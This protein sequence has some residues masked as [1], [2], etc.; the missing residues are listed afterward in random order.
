M[1]RFL[2]LLSLFI[3]FESNA[4]F[5]ETYFENC[6]NESDEF[7]SQFVATHDGQNIIGVYPAEMEGHTLQWVV[8]PQNGGATF[9]QSDVI[10][11]EIGVTDKLLDLFIIGNQQIIL[12]QNTTGANPKGI[13]LI[14]Y[15][16]YENYSTSLGIPFDWLESTVQ[17]QRIDNQLFLFP[18]DAAGN[19]HKI[20][21]DLLN[22]TLVSDIVLIPGFPFEDIGSSTVLHPTYAI[23]KSDLQ[24]EQIVVIENDILYRYKYFNN[25][26]SSW[27]TS[28]E[29]FKGFAIDLKNERILLD[30]ASDGGII[31]QLEYSND[32]NINV[33]TGIPL[34][35]NDLII[36]SLITVNNDSIVVT[37]LE[38]S[39]THA[40][41]YNQFGIEIKQ[42]QYN[43]L[44]LRSLT[45]VN[46]DLFCFGTRY[47][48]YYDEFGTNEKLAPFISFCSFDNLF[49]FKEYSQLLEFGEMKGL[50]L[51]TAPIIFPIKNNYLSGYQS[52]TLNNPFN[53]NTYF[54]QLDLAGNDGTLYRGGVRNFYSSFKPGPYTYSF[55]YSYQDMYR[56]NKGIFIDRSMIVNHINAVQ[57]GSSS[58]IPIDAILNWPA[59]GDGFR[60]QATQLAPFVDLN[61]NQLYE[62]LLGDYPSF[63]GF[64]CYYSIA[65]QHENDN[66]YTGSG[67]ELHQFIYTQSCNDTIARTLFVKTIVINRS[68]I[69]YDSLAIGIFS[70]FDMAFFDNDYPSF[71]VTTGLGYIYNKDASDVINS[72]LHD[73]IPA[74]GVTILKGVKIENDGLD[75]TIGISGNTTV[76]GFGMNDGIIDNE[77]FGTNFGIDYN[78]FATAE[79]S[80]PS[81]THQFFN[82]LNGKTRYGNP[83][84]YQ[85]ILNSSSAEPAT[86]FRFTGDSDPLH[87]STY[88]FDPGFELSPE[89]CT[90]TGS[91]FR[92][93]NSTGST[94][95][96][97][98]DSITLDFA[99]SYGDGFPSPLQSVDDL[100]TRIATSKAYFNANETPCGQNFDFIDEED[101]L[102]NVNENTENQIV[103]YPNPTKNSFSILSDIEIKNCTILAIDGTCIGQYSQPIISV[104]DFQQGIYIII[105]ED[106][107][108]NKT[109]TR[110]I[111]N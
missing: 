12:S 51:G 107:V 77:Y 56:Y 50:F 43:M 70:D 54:S 39:I 101:E 69:N 20:T 9:Y 104:T 35:Y 27:E 10:F 66:S 88:G 31:I 73:S 89:Y 108:G 96:Y 14:R 3:I 7:A 85:C 24:Y 11:E 53:K 47:G 45:V 52:T 59:H 102:L 100:R 48:E 37:Y 29:P 79:F 60:G 36:P 28:T 22:L 18:I 44:K 4:Q 65:H 17:H 62:P 95:L 40:I 34:M 78:A 42:K 8:K 75:N 1:K 16:D 25:S 97:T 64:T 33:Q 13:R 109:T 63:P 2:Y 103:L 90:S 61:N 84:Q 68:T 21:V 58:Y 80:D 6:E 30:K 15:T 106:V 93:L 98:N 71:D 92:I 32:L 49:D 55:D 19:L 111:K 41:L 46:G 83:I 110:L 91:D 86:R 76:N 94:H 87:F 5:N 72:V 38:N 81:T 26:L 67:V 74:I 99:Y 23:L 82:Y 105:V 57:S